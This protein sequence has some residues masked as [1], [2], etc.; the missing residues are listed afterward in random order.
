[1]DLFS[2]TCGNFPL[3]SFIEN[4]LINP[5]QYKKS[6]LNRLTR[7]L[8]KVEQKN[9]KH[10]AISRNILPLPNQCLKENVRNKNT[11][12]STNNLLKV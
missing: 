8:Q 7:K 3:W 10:M 1:M 6:K 2:D 9:G 11:Q 5:K 4:M 12:Q